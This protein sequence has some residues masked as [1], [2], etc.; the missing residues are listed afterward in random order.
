MEIEKLTKEE[1]NQM[2]VEVRKSYRFLYL[3]QQR[4]LDLVKFI[5][6]HFE[7]EYWGAWSHYSKPFR[8]GKGKLENWAWDWLPMY[9]IEFG[10]F[11]QMKDIEFSILLQCDTG[12]YDMDKPTQNHKLKVEAFAKPENSKT[13]IHLVLRHKNRNIQEYK[14]D[15]VKSKSEDFFFDNSNSEILLGYKIPLEN[16]ID[17]KSTRIELDEFTKLVR[18]KTSIALFSKTMESQ[19]S[20]E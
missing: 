11:T 15:Q 17:E 1:L 8:N 3:F 16:L 2:L 12:Y 13:I 20:D 19:N 6:S 9:H 18:L 4:V 14:N 10:F 5:G 7:F